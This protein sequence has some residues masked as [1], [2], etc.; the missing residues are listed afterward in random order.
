MFL[1]SRSNRLT[2]DQ[3]HKLMKQPHLMG[4]G[5]DCVDRLQEV[6]KFIDHL[7]Q[8]NVPVYGITT[9]FADLRN[10]VVSPENA[11][12][13]SWNI[14]KSHDAGI[15]DVL[16]H[17][18]V[19]G[20]MIVRAN[21]LAKGYSGFQ[22]ASLK[23][24]IGM[25]NTR[26]IPEIPCCGSLGASGDLALLARLGRAM[27]GDDVPVFYQ[28][29]R[30]SASEALSRAGIKPFLPQAKEGLALTN[31]TSFMASMAALALLKEVHLLETMLA[32]QPLF[33]ESVHAVDAAFAAPIHH[34]R[35]QWGQNWVASL[36]HKQIKSSALID[37]KGIQNDY[38]IRCIPQILGPK[39]ELLLTSAGW[40]E[41]ELDAV[42]DNPLIFKG[43]ELGSD[44]AAAR[45]ILFQEEMWTVVSG[46]NF[47]GEYLTTAADSI[48]ML[49]AKIALLLERQMTYLLNPFRNQ[50]VL[51]IYLINHTEAAGLLSGYMITQY[52]GNDIAQRIAALGTPSSLHNLTS[53]NESEDVVS[54][55][56]TACQRLLSQLKFFEDLLTI[57]L[58]LIMQAYSIRRSAFLPSLSSYSELLYQALEKKI[59]IP[60]PYK[61]DS[62]FIERYAKCKGAIEAK[63]A[64]AHLEYP[65]EKL[66]KRA[67]SMSLS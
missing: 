61:E 1:L 60:H 31:G 33:L 23:T 22:V 67:E 35:G 16:D 32:L 17:D 15:G 54:Y 49:N 43:D 42:T 64:R 14:I 65:L 48:T 66:L 41:A 29:L 58:T 63:I 2:L 44:I 62:D 50:G 4:L 24:L 12:L 53:A 19:L 45:Q 5:E 11:A 6:R 30:M 56:S 51:P 9:G 34:V 28:G 26:I 46:G 59:G 21:A 52:T 27:A 47:H 55:G 36:L 7:L 13:L 3:F 39:I 37:T 40:I 18:V 10:K 20:A 8:E 57:Y 38:C 25:I